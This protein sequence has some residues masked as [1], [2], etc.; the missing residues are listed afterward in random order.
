VNGLCIAQVKT[1]KGKDEMYIANTGQAR[2]A[3]KT[4]LYSVLEAIA[5]HAVVEDA[6]LVRNKDN[7]QQQVQAAGHTIS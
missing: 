3:Y 6:L 7:K 2:L 1:T 4:H 5:E